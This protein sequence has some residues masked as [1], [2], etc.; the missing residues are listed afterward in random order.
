MQQSFVVRLQGSRSRLTS[1]VLMAALITAW[2]APASATASDPVLEWNTIMNATV[3]AGGTS[4]LVTTRVVALVSAAVFDAVNGIEP[5]CEPIHVKPAG[6]RHASQRAAAVQAAY[7]ML[8]TLYPP[9]TASLATRRDASIAAL[10][11]TERP[12]SINAGIAWG[13]KAAEG[14]AAWRATDGFA[15]TPA[16][17]LGVQSIIGLP[18]A[19]GFWRPTPL[20]DGSPGTSGAAPQFASMTPW[21][22]RRPSQF[23]PAP[24]LA[25]ASAEYAADY[26]E[27]KIMG[28]FTGSARS[29]DQSELA[30]FWNG[31]TA[32]FWNR[33]ANQIATASFMSLLET[34]HLFARLN[35]A[36]ADAAIACW[37]AKYRYT[38][39]RPITAIRS[40]DLDGNA[41]TVPDPAWKPWLDFFPGGTPSHPEYPSGHSTVSGA[42]AFTLEMMFGDNTSFTVDSDV[43]PGTRAFATFSAAVD[44]IADARVFGGIHYRTACVRGN[45]VGRA[46]A[47][48]VLRHAMRDDRDRD[49]HGR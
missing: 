37:D 26:N 31:N 23:R 33:I 36:M 8:V 46:V 48:Y 25:L 22:L 28:S 29:S 41:A 4:P 7:A 42:A 5:R 9:Q 13:Q 1:T 19:I 49:D 10:M 6:P 15:P 34:A 18:A 45:A 2:P 47:E 12:A 24:P 44:E 40:G 27:T 14:I 16:P 21:V 43:R 17:F 38:F 11:A 30:L 32:L 39:W 3:I 20:G 35:V